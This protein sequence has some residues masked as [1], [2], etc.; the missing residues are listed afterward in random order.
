MF[1]KCF[2][3]TAILAATSGLALANG[4][5]FVPPPHHYCGD[6]YIGAG[7]SSDTY[8]LDAHTQLEVAS[9]LEVVRRDKDYGADGWNGELVA[10]YGYTFNHNLYLGGEIFGQYSSARGSLLG[11]NYI[12]YSTGTSEI[13]DINIRIPR[14]FG[15]ALVPGYRV[16][17][18]SLFYGRVGYVNSR[19]EFN[20]SSQD[21]PYTTLGETGIPLITKNANGLQLGLGVNTQVSNHISIQEGYSWNSYQRFSTSAFTSE[22]PLTQVRTV[23]FNPDLEQF[24]LTFIYHFMPNPNDV[25]DHNSPPAHLGHQFY[26]GLLGSRDN[27][28]FNNKIVELDFVPGSPAPIPDNYSEQRELDARGWD[29]ELLAGYGY[30]FPNRYYLGA[31]IFGD[32]TSIKA[33][34]NYFASIPSIP[35]AQNQ[36]FQFKVDHSAGIV[37]MPGYQVSDNALLYVRAGYINSR[38]KVNSS[39]V[40]VPAIQDDPGFDAVYDNAF[41]KSVG[42]VQIGVGVETGTWHNISVRTEFDWNK[43]Q[44]ISNIH[45]GQPD[46]L[47]GGVAFGVTTE[48]KPVIKQFKVGFVYHFYGLSGGVGHI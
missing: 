37:V 5:S 47:D 25:P 12:V 10:G 18:G 6:F 1:K 4:G 33:N 21:N 7:I 8:F 20:F 11:L 42:G 29:G 16:A 19:F 15:I 3:S 31:E 45:L 44:N 9:P 43:Y 38:F 40:F 35:V 46:P 28:F 17:P 41:S 2:L 34:D 26:V 48:V 13:Q 30:T 39:N 24:N 23:A 22:G 14:T 32:L 36:P 27:G